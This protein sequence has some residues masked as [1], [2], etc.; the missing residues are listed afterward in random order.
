[1]KTFVYVYKKITRCGR[2]AI[3]SGSIDASD[4]RDAVNKICPEKIIVNIREI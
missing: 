1:M 4:L 2:Y 3:Y